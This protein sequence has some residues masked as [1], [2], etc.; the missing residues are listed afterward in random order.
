MTAYAFHSYL[1]QDERSHEN[2]NVIR[3]GSHGAGLTVDYQF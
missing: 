2:G 3:L 1:G